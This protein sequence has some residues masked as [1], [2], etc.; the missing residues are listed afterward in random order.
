M[1]LRVLKTALAVVI[2]IYLA[3]LMGLLSPV[4]AGLLAIL[5]IEVTKKKGIRSVVSRIAASILGLLF[6]MLLFSLLGFHVWVI[7]LFILIVYPLLHRMRLREGI[8]TGSVVMFHLYTM[9]TTDAFAVLNEI[10]LLIVGLGTA[11]LINIAYMPKADKEIQACKEKV[12]HLFSQIFQQIVLHL[13]DM[14]AV[15]DGKELLEA[16]EAVEKGEQLASKLLDNTLIFQA[17]TYWRVYF[18]MRGQQLDSIYRMADLVAQIY[19]TLPQ[20][21]FIAT[22]FEELSADVKEEYYVGRTNEALAVLEQQFRQMPL[23]ITREEFEV[24]SAMLQLIRELA[25][26]LSIAKQQKKQKPM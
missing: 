20:G 15:W 10:Q 25:H 18:F 24:R 12:E 21:E 16:R 8:I 13:R 26:F 19:Q 23:P 5:G 3:S 17:K 22:I 2:S 7:G 14:E 4:S 9:K 1:G 6:A 11:T